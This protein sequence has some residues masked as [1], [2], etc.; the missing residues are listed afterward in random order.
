MLISSYKKWP[1]LISSLWFSACGGESDSNSDP[2]ETNK[3]VFNIDLSDA[4]AGDQYIISPFIL[5]DTATINGKTS[6]VAGTFT[7]S[8]D[9]ATELNIYAIG[10]LGEGLRA[11]RRTPNSDRHIL[12]TII[13]REDPSRFKDAEAFAKSVEKK[14]QLDFHLS[15]KLNFDK[16]YVSSKSHRKLTE[17]RNNPQLTQTSSC[18]SSVYLYQKED[19]IETAGLT[20]REGDDYCLL[21]IGNTG[22]SE[23]DPNNVVTSINRAFTTF[24]TITGDDFTETVSGYSYKPIFIVLP[25]DDPTYWPAELVEVFGAFSSSDTRRNLQ[26][27]I[28]LASDQLVAGDSLDDPTAAFHSVLAHE[29]GHSVLDYKRV[30]VQGEGEGEAETL[31]IDEGFAHLMEDING[32][33]PLNFEEYAGS[34]LIGYSI[35]GDE[36]V[37]I[38]DETVSGLEFTSL[39][40]GAAQTFFYYLTSQKGGITFGDDGY[41]S[42]GDGL[43]F[44]QAFYNS[45]GAVAGLETA[46]GS[47]WSEAFSNYLAALWVNNSDRGS[48]VHNVQ[49]PTTNKNLQGVASQYGMNFNNFDFLPTLAERLSDENYTPLNTAELTDVPLDYYQIKPL[50]ITVTET[51][52]ELLLVFKEAY[53]NAGVS[54]IRVK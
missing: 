44:L 2:V 3:S 1:I 12:R 29:F 18:P 53:D 26:P 42:G 11:K 39:M 50:H 16:W 25:T 14:Y 51:N 20:K 35:E 28:Y 32:Y 19:P 48:A 15:G 8:S 36:S 13:N 9:S 49:T 30:W 47:S 37:A 38:F 23:T 45:T 10:P 46:Y 34:F 31:S 41:I 7:I 6:S 54:I 40:R 33:G 21:Y 22:I 24:K 17:P 43:T 5:G 52:K 4:E 27:T